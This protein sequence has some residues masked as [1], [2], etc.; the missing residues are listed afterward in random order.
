MAA[1][2]YSIKQPMDH[3]KVKEEIKKKKYL[4]TN[5]TEISMV[6]NLWDTAKALLR[7]TFIAIQSYLN[8]KN[9][10]GREDP[11]EKEMATHSSTLA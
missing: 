10:K 3:E 4:E 6:Q 9:L 1:K 5:E 2:Q 8:Q 11:L 7:G